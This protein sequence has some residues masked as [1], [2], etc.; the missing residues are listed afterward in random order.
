R[1]QHIALLVE[2]QAADPESALG[3]GADGFRGRDGDGGLHVDGLLECHD[4]F[5]LRSAPPK[6]LGSCSAA[7]VSRMSPFRLVSSTGS[8]LPPSSRITWRPAP[9]GAV[10]ASVS[11]ITTSCSKSPCL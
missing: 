4:Y 9:P 7:V 11:P 8:S 3:L 10:G 2:H 6:A 5:F 1:L